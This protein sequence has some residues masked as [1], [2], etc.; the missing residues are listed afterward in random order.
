MP[1]SFAL[2]LPS[3]P[4]TLALAAAGVAVASA[5]GFFAGWLKLHRGVATP[6]TRKIFHF[7]IFTVATILHAIGGYAEV[8]AFACGVVAVVLF[9]CAR[10]A[11]FLLYEP[12]ARE[13]DAPHRTFFILVPLVTTALGGIVSNLVAG[14]F[15][16]V[17][18]LVTGWGDAVGEPAGR[19]F[20]RHPYRVPS[21]MGVPAN[22]TVEGSTAVGIAAFAAA[23]ISLTLALGVPI[24]KACIVALVVAVATVA[25]EAVSP[26][27]TDNFT[28]MVSA[29]WAASALAA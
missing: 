12:L 29:A 19:R 26:H 2:P 18:Y 8:N 5:A 6:Y 15:A 23:A 27:G 14:D 3:A 21:L 7:A 28:T 20:G 11:G 13:R 22:R 25:V 4:A 9:A 16:L 24:P 10:G 17:G 1:S